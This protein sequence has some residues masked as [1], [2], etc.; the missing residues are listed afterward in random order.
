MFRLT[1]HFS[2]M[3]AVIM[4]A[5]TIALVAGFHWSEKRDL[6]RHA[7]ERNSSLARLIAAIVWS[8]HVAAFAGVG[9][10]TRERL[11]ERPETTRLDLHLGRLTQD[12]GI[13]KVKLYSPEGLTIYSSEHRQIGESK[14]IDRQFQAFLRTRQPLSRMS[15]RPSFVAM[16]GTVT[17]RWIAET[18]TPIV[19]D[20]GMVAGVVEVYGDVTDYVTRIRNSAWSV[21]GLG[22]LALGIL[23]VVLLLVVRR[24]DA[25]L[26]DQYQRLAR[27]NTDL[28]RGVAE[29]TR[30][31]VAQQ[32]V[33]S[34]ITKSDDFRQGSSREAM[35]SMVRAA[36]GVL[37][38][39]RASIWLVDEARSALVRQESYDTGKGMSAV[40]DKLDLEQHR[41]FLDALERSECVAFAQAV[42]DPAA[43]CLA[44]SYLRPLGVASLLAAAV[45]HKGRLEGFVLVER[46]GVAKAWAPEQQ[47]FAS[48]LSNLVEVVLERSERETAEAGLKA[49]NRSVESANRAK[50]LFLANMSHEIRTP[51]NGVFGMTD[52]LLRTGLD[53]RQS[54]LAHTI[55][56]SARNLLGIINDILDISRIETGKLV[57]D[58]HE[59]DPRHVLEETVELLSEEA[60]R[61]EVDLSLYVGQHVPAVM[62]DAGR[63]RQVVTNIVANAIK[64]TGE[65]AVRVRID[66]EPLPENR[67]M[68]IIVVHDT[69][70]GIPADVQARLFQPFEQADASIT[71]R[72][73]GTGLGL[74]ISRH[75][76]EMMGGSISIESRPGAGTT[77]TIRF[78][79]ECAAGG[80]PTDRPSHT[81]LHGRRVLVLDDRA[82]NREIITTYL[83]E[84]GARTTGVERPE[85]ALGLLRRAAREG[86]PYAL[87][88]I[89][90]VLPGTTGLEVG[91]RIAAD[92]ALAGTRLVMLTSMSWKG[93]TRMAREQGFNAF[94]SKPVRRADLI[95]T[96]CRVIDSGDPRVA[97]TPEVARPPQRRLVGARVLV[98]EDNPVNLEVVREYL[99][100][101]GCRVTA[102]VN[103]TEA[104]RHF[105]AQRFDAALVDCQMPEMDGLTA[106]RRMRAHEEQTGQPHTPIIAVTANAFE[107]D[108][109][110]CLAAG[111]DDYVRKPFTEEALEAALVRWLK[112]RIAREASPAMPAK[113]AEA[114]SRHDGARQP[115]V[116]PAAVGAG[117]EPEAAPVLDPEQI[118][119]LQR[120]HAKLLAR[121]ASTYLAYAPQ[122]LAKL[123]ADLA[124]DDARS[125]AAGAHSL[126]SSSA[127]V[128]A[129]RLANLCRDLEL[130]AKPLAAVDDCCRG[131][132]AAVAAEYVL[133]EAAL[134][135][136]S[137]A[138]APVAAPVSAQSA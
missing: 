118:T 109:V 61:K 115:V 65:G 136:V 76:V 52:L 33:L 126:K 12:L 100:N 63:L 20:D 2:A 54:R 79:A 17:D 46:I 47:L 83:E 37:G 22:V 67:A 68:V 18:Y 28:E 110:A 122:A 21:A 96:A 44:D 86:E 97:T 38:A 93:D 10:A 127:N 106:T 13:L 101:L 53:E 71:R 80:R 62:G 85:E 29:R 70:V 78:P 40:I 48:A 116:A 6:G 113:A 91:R 130:H 41:P 88:V 8:D 104:C 134:R 56:R 49:A 129:S 137:A 31:L 27:F 7:A 5:I 92:P 111:M 36:V 64:F 135:E 98:A 90:M 73:G 42:I 84:H 108:R 32:D 25:I 4:A 94:L 57:L 50:S 11:I 123:S 55:Q 39:D 121:L 69:G 87:A 43:V 14:A 103:G 77:V 15:F 112:P 99:E 107:E 9:T 102:A 131:L 124:L 58:R 19:A 3:S 119:R 45:S 60:G 105:A 1:R 117:P 59:Y 89:D 75:L 35:R 74:S 16:Q 66:A 125:V 81:R 24:A 133:V 51:M 138:T 82:A 128:G 34:W 26:R 132:V 114:H 72:F 120:T 30:T 23:Y 95:D